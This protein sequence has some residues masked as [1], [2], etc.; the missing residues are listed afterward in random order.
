MVYKDKEK[1]RQNKRE[2]YKKN[3]D[4]LDKYKKE[5]ERNNPEKE[6]SYSNNSSE[7]RRFGRQREIIL[8]RDNWQCQ[9][10]GMSQEQ[11]IILFNRGLII[12]HKDGK[13][14][15]IKNRNDKNNDID[16]LQTLCLRCHSKLNKRHSSQA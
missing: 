12:H 6:R 8:E 3:K 4:R 1:L 15:N 16:N 14:S 9:E 13:G 5:W 7:R 10:C 2:Y 11:H